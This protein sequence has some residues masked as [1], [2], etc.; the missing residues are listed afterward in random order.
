MKKLKV[1]VLNRLSL[2][3][4]KQIGRSIANRLIEPLEFL[5]IKGLVEYEILNPQDITYEIL[6]SKKF[7]VAFLNK[8]CDQSSLE[9]ARMIFSLKI[10]IIYDLDDNIFL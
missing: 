9:V 8:S 6:K 3:D 7:D 2:V 5:S 1:L 4:P 10:K